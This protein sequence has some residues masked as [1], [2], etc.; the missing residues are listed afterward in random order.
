MI[1]MLATSLYGARQ[2]DT[3]L[4]DAATMFCEHSRQKHLGRRPSNH[5]YR[6]VTELGA[7]IAE[8]KFPGIAGGEAG[9]IM[10]RYERS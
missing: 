4:Q 7:A 10:M 3:I 8:G 6:K 5:Y 9:E 2:G 1:T